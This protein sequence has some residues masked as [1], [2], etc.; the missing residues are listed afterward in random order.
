MCARISCPGTSGAFARP[1]R[2]P[3]RTGSRTGAERNPQARHPRLDAAARVRIMVFR[4]PKN[5]PKM[6]W[7]AEGSYRLRRLQDWDLKG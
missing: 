6:W 5:A 1:A 4:T 7:L 3:L 2:A